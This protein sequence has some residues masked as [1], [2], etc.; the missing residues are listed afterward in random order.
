[1]GRPGPVADAEVVKHGAVPLQ[2]VPEVG[3]RAARRRGPA[4]FRQRQGAGERHV[5][6]LR[7]VGD[8]LGPVARQ[9]G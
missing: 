3:G 4:H 1:M 8:V 9:S 5:F 6:D 7:R 2:A